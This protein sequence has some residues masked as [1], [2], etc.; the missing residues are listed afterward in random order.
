[1]MPITQRLKIKTVCGTVEDTRTPAEPGEVIPGRDEALICDLCVSSSNILTVNLSGQL[2][3]KSDNLLR[4]VYSS[5]L[6][7][8]TCT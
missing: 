8:I 4:S 1:M 2:K 3:S 6:E 5:T 7:S